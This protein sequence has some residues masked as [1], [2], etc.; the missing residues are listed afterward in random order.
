MHRGIRLFNTHATNILRLTTWLNLFVVEFV[1]VHGFGARVWIGQ[2]I[3][4]II[5][6]IKGG[7]NKGSK[8]GLVCATSMNDL[9]QT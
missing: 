4:S 5:S 1:G 3:G 6:S 9:E 7:S 8:N 2:F